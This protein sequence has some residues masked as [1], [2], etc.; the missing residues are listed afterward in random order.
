MFG[1][2][3]VQRLRKGQVT[4]RPIL[5]DHAQW[6]GFNQRQVMP[7]GI[8][9]AQH[10]QERTVVETLQRDHVDLDLKTRIPGGANALKRSEEHTSELQSLMRISY[11]VFCLKK[12]KKSTN[13]TNAPHTTR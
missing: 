7:L 13:I 6:H 12:K 9:P 8:A 4:V 11:A 10:G 5:I 1:A 2:D 3:L